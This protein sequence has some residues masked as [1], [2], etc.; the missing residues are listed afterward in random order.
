VYNKLPT[1]NVLA[2]DTH[3]KTTAEPRKTVPSD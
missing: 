2:S 3:M 1:S